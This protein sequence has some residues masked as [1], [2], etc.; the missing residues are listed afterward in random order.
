MSKQKLGRIDFEINRLG[1]GAMHLSIDREKRPTDEESITLIRRAVDE[2]GIDFIDTADAYCL[3]ESEKGHN[4]R[5]I[6]QALEGERRNRVVVATKGGC[7]RPEG[8]WERDG[9]PEYLRTAC[10]ASLKALETDNIDLYQL[11]APDSNVPVEES[12]GTLRTLQEEGKIRH[13]GLSNFTLDQLK[14]GMG[15]ADIVSL[16]NQYSVMSTR[17][18]DELIA[19]CEEQEIIY[20][21]WNPIGGRGNAPEI[22]NLYETLGEIASAHGVTPH[23]I[24]LSWLLNRSPMMLPIPGTRKFEHLSENMKALEIELSEEEKERLNDL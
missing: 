1:Y 8:R 5:L 19:F 24:A 22:G 11:H 17:A 23:T 3:D 12:V 7:I 20:I 4:E 13:I 18:Q 21:P 16:Q 2:L 9:R 10:E 14:R 15:E 6:A